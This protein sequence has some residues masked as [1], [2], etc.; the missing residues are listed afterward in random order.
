MRK[1]KSKSQLDSRN[2]PAVSLSN[3]PAVSLPNLPHAIIFDMDGVL[4]YTEPFIK[5]ALIKVFAE[6]GLTI[7]GSYLRRFTGTGEMFCISTIAKENA[8]DIDIIQTKNLVQKLYYQLIEGNLKVPPYVLDFLKKCR[9]LGKKLAVATSSDSEKLKKNFH[10]ADLDFDLFDVIVT[11]DDVAN[12]KPA[13]DIFLLTA[14]KLGVKI[15]ECLIVE[16]AVT[17]IVAAHAAGARCLALTTTFSADEL[18]SADYL[19]ENLSRVPPHAL[20]W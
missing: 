14:E 1:Q 6:K 17:G 12:K 20:N 7:A 9:N 10:A 18:S 4:L 16:D 3:L 2:L 13:P 11:G 8:L 19:A 15:D 5:Q